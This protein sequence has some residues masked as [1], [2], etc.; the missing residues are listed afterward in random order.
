MTTCLIVAMF[1]LMGMNTANAYVINPATGW[2]G[3]FGWNDG[4]GQMDYILESDLTY[5]ADTQWTMALPTGG[6]LSF[7]TAYDHLVAGDQFALYI[8]GVVKPWDSV[9]IDGSGYYHGMIYAEHLAAGT[10]SFYMYVTAL[11]PG[12][13]YG[14]A[15]ALFSAVCEDCCTIPAPGAI[16]LGSIGVSIVGWMR[17]R[18]TL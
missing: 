4:L 13:I 6:T 14:D 17:R 16:L 1:I 12:Y 10:H 9:I 11:A 2:S 5:V 7:A 8:D 3:Y 15:R 18:R